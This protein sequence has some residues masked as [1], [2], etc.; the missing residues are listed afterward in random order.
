MPHQ[1][2]G[3]SPL[4]RRAFLSR[5]AGGIG[6]LA[7]SHLLAD[8]AR[9][10]ASPAGW[11]SVTETG[12]A[13]SFICLWLIRCFGEVTEEGPPIPVEIRFLRRKG[14]ERLCF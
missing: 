9:G 8:R 13:K 14:S 1:V 5:Y 3:W 7:V 4:S 11:P 10:D 6:S 12:Q 2:P